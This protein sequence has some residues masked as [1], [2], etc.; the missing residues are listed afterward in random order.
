MQLCNFTC[1]MHIIHIH[2]NSYLQHLFNIYLLSSTMFCRVLLR[3]HNVFYK[4]FD[5]NMVINMNITLYLSV[6]T[7]Y[8]WTTVRPICEVKPW[9]HVLCSG[10]KPEP[11]ELSLPGCGNVTQR[12]ENWPGTQLSTTMGH[13]GPHDPW[14]HQANISPVFPSFFLFPLIFP[15]QLFLLI[16]TGG[17]M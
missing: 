7:G 3:Q 11:P 16:P 12:C 13:S 6:G 2:I 5:L 14:G 10:D 15:T 1:S 17:E 8:L 4:G 9:P